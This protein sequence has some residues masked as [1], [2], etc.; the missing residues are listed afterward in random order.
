MSAHPIIAHQTDEDCRP[1]VN[2]VSGECRVCHVLHGDP[3]PEC[4]RR[5]QHLTECRRVGN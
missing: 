4:G 3:C 2:A 5:G 1:Y